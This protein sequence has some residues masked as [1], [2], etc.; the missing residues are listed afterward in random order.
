MIIGM[1]TRADRVKPD[2]V[3]VGDGEEE[4]SEQEFYSLLEGWSIA[5]SGRQRA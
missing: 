5:C 2:I 3:F 1:A 4:R